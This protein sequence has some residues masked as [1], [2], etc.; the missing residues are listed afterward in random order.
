MPTYAYEAMNQAGQDIKDEIEAHSSEDALA[1]IR[2]LGY[3]PTRI[4]EKGG[5]R[6]RAAIATSAAHLG[7]SLTLVTALPPEDPQAGQ[8][9]PYG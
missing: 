1:K 4:R 5:A 3:F 8:A 7:S 6:A 2:N 9:V